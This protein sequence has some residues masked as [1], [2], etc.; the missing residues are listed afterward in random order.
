MGEDGDEGRGEGV[1]SS[2]GGR[3][4]AQPAGTPNRGEAPP[5]RAPPPSAATRG[6]PP[7]PPPPRRPPRRPRNRVYTLRKPRRFWA[8]I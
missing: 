5:A 6:A 7:P 4:E 1:G 2:E 3:E 8:A